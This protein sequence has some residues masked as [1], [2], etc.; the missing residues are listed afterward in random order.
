MNSHSIRNVFV[1]TMW[2]LVAVTMSVTR[3]AS[4]AVH[5]QQD[6]C[7]LGAQLTTRNGRA[8]SLS[9]SAYGPSA[10]PELVRR[11]RSHNWRVRYWS[12]AALG[13]IG[14]RAVQRPI[15]RLIYDRDWRV[16]VSALLAFSESLAPRALLDA[17]L[18]SP[19]DTAHSGVVFEA[20]RYAHGE[21][22]RPILLLAIV[23]RIEHSRY[24]V[25]QATQDPFNNSLPYHD[26][27]KIGGTYI[28][29]YARHREGTPRSF[30]VLSVM[31][32]RVYE[33]VISFPD[34]WE[35]SSWHHS[36]TGRIFPW[37]TGRMAVIV[38][39]ADSTISGNVDE[40][41]LQCYRLRAH[42]WSRA[43]GTDEK[44]VGSY[45]NGL[46]FDK[47]GD[48]MIHGRKLFIWQG[49][50]GEHSKGEEQHYILREF[51]WRRG[52]LVLFSA[53]ETREIYAP[54]G[55]VDP[56]EEFGLRSQGLEARSNR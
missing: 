16:S 35:F 1:A 44:D 11:A 10:I 20:Y 17:R 55:K 24:R 13:Q 12:A 36:H 39:I 49:E 4:G 50:G 37:T 27:F 26:V 51:H 14:G 25:L 42:T 3:Y 19:R 54:G 28:H 34:G 21:R 7:R 8:A 23:D 15:L 45:E 2:S 47:L 5:S 32:R 46:G 40:Y 56:L 52:R 29:V 43:A 33:Q 53:R 48:F 22:Q 31:N 9:L 38:F 30:C 18:P 41:G 6:I